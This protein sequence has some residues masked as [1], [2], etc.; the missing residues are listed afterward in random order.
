LTFVRWGGKLK[1]DIPAGV[2]FPAPSSYCTKANHTM[3]W[4]LILLVLLPLPRLLS[5]AEEIS[6]TGTEVKE[7]EYFDRHITELMKKYELPGGTAAVA[8]DGR[9]VYVRGFGWADRKNRVP[10]QPT[11]LMRIASISKP[12]TAAVILQLIEQRRLK[13]E[14]PILPYL[15]KF[16]ADTENR[17]DSRWRQIT[18]AHLL[19]HTAGFDRGKS[20]D[21]MFIPQ[22][23]KP[24]LDQ[25]AIIRYML[26]RPLDFDPGSRYVYSNFD[27]CMLGRVIE[28]VT[29]KRYEDA[30]REMVLRPAGITR[31]KLGKTRRADRAE[32]EVVYHM[33]ETDKRCKSV[34]PEEKRLVDE[35]YGD[36][37]LEALDSHGGWIASAADLVRFAAALDGQRRPRI[38]SPE[39][40]EQTQSLSDPPVYTGNGKD[41]YYGLGWVIVSQP[42]GGYW[43]H[44]GLLAG[45][46]TM[47]IRY[48]GVV[49]AVLF[50]GQSAEKGNFYGELGQ[51][52]LKA[53]DEVKKWPKGDLF[54]QKPYSD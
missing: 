14:D 39:S 8:K 7:L 30:V 27:Y 45:T 41:R 40:I 43:F 54:S 25:A 53:A 34:F 21:P 52:L 16:G 28:A 13:L 4:T 33:R 9:L 6:R 1:V 35:P 2:S 37:Y 23:P 49:M 46:R 51:T 47:L 26:G 38:L 18:I 31:M 50:N 29:G 10:M 12:F 15:K 36:F 22:L 17:L 32:G 20:F 42:N 44:D 24:P 19:R 11:A 5:A 3:R 48:H